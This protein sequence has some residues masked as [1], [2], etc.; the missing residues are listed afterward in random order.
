ME[1]AVL[2]KYIDKY[3]KRAL[4]LDVYIVPDNSVSYN[5]NIKCNVIVYPDKFLEKGSD[6]SEKY[7]KNLSNPDLILNKLQSGLQLLGRESLY[8]WGGIAQSLL[9]KKQDTFSIYYI[10]SKNKGEYLNQYIEKLLQVIDE[11]SELKL[12]SNKS[13]SKL[14]EPVTYNIDVR[15]NN[16][17]DFNNDNIYPHIF[18]SIEVSSP[19]PIGTS[20]LWNDIITVGEEFKQKLKEYNLLDPQIKFYFNPY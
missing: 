1:F 6:F 20:S 11:I 14:L 13:Y 3:I 17:I 10:I 4:D 19:N 8:L 2:N 15:F 9:T 7:K 12:N 18:L 5:N 16:N